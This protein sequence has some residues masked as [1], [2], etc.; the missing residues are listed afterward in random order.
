MPI[1]GMLIGG[2]DFSHLSINVLDSKIMYGAFIQ[3]IIDFLIVAFCIFIFIK[4]ING[5]TSKIK[6]EEEEEKEE[7]E[8]EE[9]EAK[10]SEE[11]ELLEEIRD[12]LKKQNK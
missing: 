11:V 10:K 5:I 3:N 6:K 4:L 2:L 8:K 7:E 9:E 12:L 1:I